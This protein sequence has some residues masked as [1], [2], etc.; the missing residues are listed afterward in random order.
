MKVNSKF[1]INKIR[2]KQL[3]TAAVRTLG[4]TADSLKKEVLYFFIRK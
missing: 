2:L 4:Q 1:T 3:S